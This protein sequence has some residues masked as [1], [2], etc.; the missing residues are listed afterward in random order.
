[1]GGVKGAGG[2]RKK[3]S[4]KNSLASRYENLNLVMSRQSSSLTRKN[5]RG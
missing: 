5:S 2:K 1:M 4:K 3:L